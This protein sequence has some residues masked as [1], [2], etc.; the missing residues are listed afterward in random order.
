MERNGVLRRTINSME[1]TFA[2]CVC[3]GYTAD[4]EINTRI[5]TF[6]DS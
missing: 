2:D 6:E 1:G 3:L 4:R 5:P